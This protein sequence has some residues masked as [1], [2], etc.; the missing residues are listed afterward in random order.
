MGISRPVESE[1]VIARAIFNSLLL[2]FI[3][4]TAFFYA[5]NLTPKFVPFP[6]QLISQGAQQIVMRV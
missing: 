6:D 5:I 4:L 1:I 3:N 2:D